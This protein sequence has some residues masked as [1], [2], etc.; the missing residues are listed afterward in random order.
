MASD[1]SRQP[2]SSRPNSRPKGERGA[3]KS[4]PP[5]PNRRRYSGP[6]AERRSPVP[7]YDR[8]RDQTVTTNAAFNV[9]CGAGLGYALGFAIAAE[10]YLPASIVGVAGAILGVAIA[11]WINR[12]MGRR[13]GS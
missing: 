7:G 12:H 2:P 11:L 3:G 4:S 1:R 10:T 6:S 13:G 9:L 8:E 5:R